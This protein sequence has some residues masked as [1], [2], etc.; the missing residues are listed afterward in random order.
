MK[1]RIILIYTL[2]IFLCTLYADYHNSYFEIFSGRQPSSRAEALGRGYVT[3]D[4]DL[5]SYFF[6][7]AGISNITQ[8]KTKFTTSSPLYLIDK[9]GITNIAWATI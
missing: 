6:N 2:L 1:K 4:N 3:V 9:Q 7:P 8:L 5:D